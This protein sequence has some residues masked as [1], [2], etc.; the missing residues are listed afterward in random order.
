MLIN[1]DKR[2]LLLENRLHLLKIYNTYRNSY[3]FL[4]FKQFID[5]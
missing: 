2:I 5:H 3:Q 4:K 1:Y